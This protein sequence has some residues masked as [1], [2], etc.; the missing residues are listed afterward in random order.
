MRRATLTILLLI[1]IAAVLAV[2]GRALLSD[3]TLLPLD[4]LHQALLP[5]ANDV[6]SPKFRDQYEID[7]VQEYLPLYHF[8]AD[9]LRRGE[10][11][12]WNPFNRGGAAYPDNPVR[13]PFHPLKLLLRFLSPD[14]VY[15]LAAV[16]HFALAFLAMT[17]YL[18]SLNLAAPAV[19][20]GALC[21]TYSGFF[22]LNFV[23]ERMIAA[24]GLLP[25]C[26]MMF[27]RLHTDPN[28]RT[29][30]RFGA[31]LGA[32]LLIAGPTA[33][34]VYLIVFAT[35]LG[36]Y[37]LLEAS[38]P[39]PARLRWLFW[40]ALL[41]AALSAPN[42][43]STVE[44]L[45]N[46]VRVFAYQSDYTAVS[47]VLGAFTA[48]IALLLSAIH[49]Y[50][51]GSRGSL[52]FLKL[53]GQT[54]TLIPFAGSF[55]LL[56]ALL[57]ARSLWLDKSLRWLL[58]LLALGTVLLVPPIAWLLSTR[59]VIL[60]T[61][62]LVVGGAIGMHRFWCGP[63]QELKRSAKLVAVFTA[64]LWFAFLLRE[65]V[66]LF[67]GD[68]LRH[69][70]RGEL[71]AKLPGYLLE[72]YPHWRIQAA[73]RF[74]DLQRIGSLP[75]VLFLAGLT[76]L[77]AAWRYY[78]RTGHR[79]ARAI[80]FLMATLAPLVFA[81]GNINIVNTRVYPVPQKPDYLMTLRGPDPGPA[82]IAI[83]LQDADDRLL[84]PAL[85]PQLFDLAQVRGY[86]SLLPPGPAVLTRGLPLAHPL[87]AVLGVNYLITARDSPVRVS[88]YTR[89][90]Y[91]GEVNIYAREPLSSRVHLA[92]RLERVASRAEATERARADARPAA[93]RAFYVTKL[94]RDYE[95]STRGPSGRVTV[96]RD[97][98]TRIEIEASVDRGALLVI[99]DTY[100]PG[101]SA[102]V[103]GQPSKIYRVDGAIQGVWLR[104]GRSNVVLR[105]IHWPS[106]IGIALQLAALFVVAFAGLF[107]AGRRSR[108]PSPRDLS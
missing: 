53:L 108:R 20:F 34:L 67:W 48:P 78:S 35:R 68:S 79:T 98:A 91:R 86:G 38:P 23:H 22:V 55:T 85:L 49:P 17:L 92:R 71:A 10:F 107:L 104:P 84:M 52:D 59:N 28:P 36:G 80:A 33:I 94:P 81:L 75:N 19:L 37:W 54:I 14:Q 87:F 103:N 41:A 96:L 46:N 58:L 60:L 77:A 65:V 88:A 93:V 70:M 18:R 64:T 25:L 43:L 100:Y 61:F 63:S 16:L 76:V 72:R 73:D 66:L 51:F 90:V 15:D 74:I 13:V 105:Y 50:V 106:R 101:W 39:G 11:P 9:S 99:G 32:G 12:T 27:E 24:I 56:F 3:E 62:V 45:A 89:S 31:V 2:P 26:L 6:Q 42:L 8:H 30:V 21:W 1:G 69:V 95:V 83:P 82:R 29:A 5:W 7:A 97:E 4:F 44:G 57:A 102:K 47:G 40:A